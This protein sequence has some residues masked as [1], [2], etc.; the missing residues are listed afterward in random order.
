MRHMV[1]RGIIGL[2]WLVAAVVSAISLNFP[3]VFFFGVMGVAFLG[4]AY[5]IW[6]KREGK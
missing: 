1:M 4:S 3:M 6:R 5:S 2:V